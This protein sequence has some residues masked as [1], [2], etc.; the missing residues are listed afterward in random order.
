MASFP[1][2]GSPLYEGFSQSTPSGSIRT[3]MEGY[4]KQAKRF[5]SVYVERSVMYY[6]TSA[7]YS[8][9]LTFFETTIDRGSLSFDWTDPITDS[10]KTARIKDSSY[11][12]S[13]VNG[14]GDIKLSMTLE[15]LE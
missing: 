8:T 4:I 7:E 5:S 9:F 11:A 13:V 14:D 15:V 3:E 6:L 1:A 12:I 2:I 10:T